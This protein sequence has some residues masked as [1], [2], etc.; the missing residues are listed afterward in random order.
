MSISFSCAALASSLG[1]AQ[2]KTAQRPRKG[3]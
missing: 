2:A 1:A 3:R